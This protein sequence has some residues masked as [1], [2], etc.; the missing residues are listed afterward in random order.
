MNFS[1]ILWNKNED[2]YNAIID[3]PFNKELMAGTLDK[4]IFAYYIEQD[5]IYL[6]SYAKALASIAV[7]ADDNE[8]IKKFADYSKYAL[9]AEEE[10]VHEYFRKTYNFNNTGKQTMATHGY[11]NFLIASTMNK[12]LEVAVAA[13]LPCFWIYYEVGNYIYNN[14]DIEN[15]PYKHWIKT[16]A[17]DDYKK[18]VDDVIAITNKL[19]ENTTDAIR[20]EM[21][22]YFSSGCMW[23]WHFWNDSYNL[24]NFFSRNQRL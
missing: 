23:E 9:I 20:Q 19:A 10:V 1:Q 5:S 3:M 24:N 8:L 15:N 22:E 21:I 6:K 7:K 17:G 2:I 18:S 4:N 12:S 13:I 14:S 11:C 16:Y